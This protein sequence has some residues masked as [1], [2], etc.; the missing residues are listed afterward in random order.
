MQTIEIFSGVLNGALD[1]LVRKV[2]SGLVVVHGRHNGAEAGI[3]LRPDGLVLTNAHVVGRRAPRVLL[4]D[5]RE[6]EA[7]LVDRD[8]EV[9]LALIEIDAR[10]LPALPV[11]EALPQVGELVFAF[12]H[13][14]GQRGFVSSGI[15]SAVGTVQTRTQRGS[16]PVIRT[17]VPL[18]PGNS[19][20][21]LV[22]GAG[23]VVGVN[24][25]IVG[26][27]QSI[28]IPASVARE[29]VRQVISGRSIPSEAEG[30]L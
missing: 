14:W 11:A 13:P 5:D 18:A 27:D 22:N 3:I 15:V 16:L 20:G 4:H 24:A 29:F 9:D 28:S 21:P 25:M 2:E 7:R 26:G 17:D 1:D 6:F 30:V 23:E 10:N 8:E 19:G 12:G